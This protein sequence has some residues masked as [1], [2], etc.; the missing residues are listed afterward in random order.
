M[1][2]NDAGAMVLLIG[3]F[4]LWM[5]LTP[6]HLLYIKPSM[7][8]WL[9]LSGAVLVTVGALVLILG[10]RERRRAR[11]A[12]TDARG[13]EA[14]DHDHHHATRVGWLLALPLCVAIAVGANPLGSYA[15]GRQNSQRVLPPGE[16]DL[17]QYLTANSFGGQAPA[18]RSID[19]VRATQDPDQRPLLADQAVTL[20]G[21]V[22]E[23]PDGHGR[24]FLLTRFMVGCCA[25]DALA[26][27]VRVPV[28]DGPL[29]EEEAWVQVEGTLDLERSPDPGE[30]LD[31]PVVRATA[32]RPTD[33]PDE[34]YEY[35]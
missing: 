26:V 35:P 30:S 22:V 5:G 9:V 31:P 16:F 25:A 10:W 27:Q 33:E 17:E 28:R 18:L 13:G 19:Y 23:D 6:T 2:R 15:A 1:R 24:S 7:T 32:I 21:F 3:G 14:D 34:V 8:R 4:A 11:A 20:T 29:P 12:G